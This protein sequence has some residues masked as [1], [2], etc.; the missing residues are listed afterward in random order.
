MA[1]LQAGVLGALVMLGCLMVGSLLNRRSIWVAPNLFATT[2]YG[3]GVYYNQ[4]ART[5]WAGVALLIVL[6]GGMGALWGCAWR[7]ERKAVAGGLRAIF[8]MVVYLVLFDFIWKQVNGL[9]VLYAPTAQLEFGHALWGMILAK[10]PAYSRRI[11]ERMLGSG[12]RRSE[13]GNGGAR[14]KQR[15]G[16]AV[17][18]LVAEQLVYRV[19]R[20]HYARIQ[21]AGFAEGS[22]F[23]AHAAG[24]AGDVIRGPRFITGGRPVKRD[25]RAH[26]EVQTTVRADQKGEVSVRLTLVR[27][28]N[29]KNSLCVLEKSIH[30]KEHIGQ[31]GQSLSGHIK[32]C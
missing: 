16:H 23:D 21:N 3:A 32:P 12:A 5:A 9:V 10:S 19:G 15:P 13:S 4:Y 20:R 11:T 2:F 7:E 24:G 25:W 14:A 6:Y 18:H 1:G 29:I 17:K 31:G 27:A 30:P 22:S 26:N 8:G 28:G